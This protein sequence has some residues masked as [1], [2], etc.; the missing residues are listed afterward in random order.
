LQS[1]TLAFCPSV[2]RCFRVIEPP[3]NAMCQQHGHQ[4]HAR[5]AHFKLQQQRFPLTA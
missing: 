3:L 1:V 2:H 5:S 4:S